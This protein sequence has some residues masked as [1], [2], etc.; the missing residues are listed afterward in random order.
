MAQRSKCV[1]G[2]DSLFGFGLLNGIV[3][4]K[5]NIQHHQNYP[6]SITEQCIEPW[7]Q[8]AWRK[9]KQLKG[10]KKAHSDIFPC[11]EI[12]ALGAQT[13]D[14]RVLAHTCDPVSNVPYSAKHK[15]NNTGDSTHA[16]VL[17]FSTLVLS[18]SVTPCYL[19]TSTF[20]TLTTKSGFQFTERQ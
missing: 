19:V 6:L 16:P 11:Q 5:K 20:G 1:S 15:G 4:N 13:L 18:V 3:D 7:P 9:N 17:L 2:T 14:K 12:G 8:S 10:E